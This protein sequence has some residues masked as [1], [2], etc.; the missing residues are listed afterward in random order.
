MKDNNDDIICLHVFSSQFTANLA[1][2][3]LRDEDIAAEI[4]GSVW[5]GVLGVAAPGAGGYRL[6]VFGRDRER[7]ARII[8]DLMD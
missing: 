4:D 2:T 8:S 5:P 3:K 6:M 1:L 7:A